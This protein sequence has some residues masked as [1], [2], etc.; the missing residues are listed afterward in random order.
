MTAL[1]LHPPS[2]FQINNMT[3]QHDHIGHIVKVFHLFE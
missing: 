2:K 1:Y 3:R